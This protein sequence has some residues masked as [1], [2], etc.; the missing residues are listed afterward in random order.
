M[1][2]QQ[3][4]TELKRDLNQLRASSYETQAAEK[5]G[6]LI[7]A[8]TNG[9]TTTETLSEEEIEAKDML[10]LAE[11][12]VTKWKNIVG[13]IRI[14]E[15]EIIEWFANDIKNLIDPQPTPQPNADPASAPAAPTEPGPDSDPDTA[16]AQQDDE[17][18]RARAKAKARERE[19]EILELEAEADE[20]DGDNSEK[21]S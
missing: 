21:K 1:V 9:F 20:E 11:C 3:M 19:I 6:D 12:P 14:S 16:P 13:K 18:E 7:E 5:V 4:L 8:R 15:H 2:T 17:Q 10:E